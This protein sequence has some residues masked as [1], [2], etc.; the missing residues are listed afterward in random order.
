[1]RL[2]TIDVKINELSNHVNEQSTAIP[3]DM[4][5]L[6]KELKDIIQSMQEEYNHECKN[7]SNIC[8]YMQKQ[9]NAY[10]VYIHTNRKGTHRT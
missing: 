6:D 1:M 9:I 4:Q 2:S 10:E 5:K 7:H 3:K 8:Y